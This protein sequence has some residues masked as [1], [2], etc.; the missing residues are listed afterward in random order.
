M[1][2]E[3]RVRGV[4]PPEAL[5]DFEELTLA[6]RKGVSVL[7]GPFRDQAALNGLF[8]RLETLGVRVMEVRQ[9]AAG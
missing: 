1:Y 6:V 2:Y 8:L 4:L 5:V 9:I 7:R 3:V